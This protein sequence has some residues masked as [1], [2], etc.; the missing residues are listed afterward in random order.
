MKTLVI[1]RHSKSSWADSDIT[2]LERPLKP[3]GKSDA[4]KMTI[5]LKENNII[6]E[7]IVSSPA[8]RA[9][10]TA[11]LISE[12]LGLSPGKVIIEDSLY[13]YGYKAVLKFV[14]NINDS[15]NTVIITG[16]NPDFTLVANQF[17]PQSIDNLPTTGV[18][19]LK[20]DCQ[21]WNEIGKENLIQEMRFIPE[22]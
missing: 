21:S 15:L 14:T 1:V 17:L 8:I 18:V 7:L 20:F 13:F 12:G 9:R 10:Q 4:M 11:E 6:P 16:H 19:V 2:D 3:I 22:T 5:Q